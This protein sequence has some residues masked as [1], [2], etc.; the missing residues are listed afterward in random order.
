[1][2]GG[3]KCLVLLQAAKTQVTSAALFSSGPSAH[4]QLLS[5]L[6]PRLP[7]V[8]VTLQAQAPGSLNRE[9][10]GKEGA[11]LRATKTSSASLVRASGKDGERQTQTVF[12]NCGW[13]DSAALFL[14]TNHTCL[15]WALYPVSVCLLVCVSPRLAVQISVRALKAP[16]NELCTRRQSITCSCCCCCCYCYRNG[17]W[18][19]VCRPTDP[20]APGPPT[21]WQHPC[22]Q[23][24]SSDCKAPERVSRCGQVHHLA[25]RAAAQV[26]GIVQQHTVAAP[27]VNRPW[28]LLPAMV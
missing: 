17:W 18:H 10:L 9:Y 7:D 5:L 8:Y 20:A 15:W 4:H 13:H 25:P 28:F 16:T 19:A 24:G 26:C 6:S 12:R 27:C 14:R 1:M 2:G 23:C 11:T 3:S 22:R 21:L